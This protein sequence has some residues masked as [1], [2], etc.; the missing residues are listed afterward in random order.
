MFNCLLIVMLS[1]LWCQVECHAAR[2]EGVSL[3]S[4]GGTILAMRLRA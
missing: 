4:L 1:A 2:R 3:T